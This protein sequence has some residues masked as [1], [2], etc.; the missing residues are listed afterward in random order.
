VNYTGSRFETPSL[1]VPYILVPGSA[2][3]AKGQS[4]TVSVQFKDPSSAPI[5]FIPAVYT[6]SVN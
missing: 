3:L 5:H 6:R 4:I 2:S 1:P